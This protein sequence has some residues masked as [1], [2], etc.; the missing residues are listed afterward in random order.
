M[1]I[2]AMAC[3]SASHPVASHQRA[4]NFSARDQH[5]EVVTLSELRGA[6]VVLYFYPRDATPGCTTEACAFR[7][8]WDRFEAS[9][10]RLLGMS[11]DSVESHRAF[12]E[13][14]RLPFSLLSD[15]GG[16][17]AASYGVSVRMGFTK[18][19][20]FLIDREGVIRRVFEDVDPGVHAEEI[21]QALSEL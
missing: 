12:A 9:G 15:E 16:A 8:V 3:G 18:R 13:E 6:P 11:T 20:T 4:P 19:T 5:R 7:D 1:L 2:L 17:I 21:L 10:A 14:H